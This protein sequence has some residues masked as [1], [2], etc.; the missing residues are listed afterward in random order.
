MSWPCVSTNTKIGMLP[1]LATMRSTSCASGSTPAVPSAIPFATPITAI[2]S[3]CL[4]FPVPIMMPAAFAFT[5]W[6]DGNRPLRTSSSVMVRLLDAARECGKVLAVHIPDSLG[7]FDT[8]NP[9]HRNGV[10]ACAEILLTLGKAL[11]LRL[12]CSEIEGRYMGEERFSRGAE[13]LHGILGKSIGSA[14]QP[15][16]LAAVGAPDQ[17]LVFGVEF[18]D[19]LVG[20]DHF[21]AGDSDPPLF[22]YSDPGAGCGRQSGTAEC[23]CLAADQCDDCHTCVA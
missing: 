4:R 13:S 11:M 17:R 23:A 20:L 19:T 1:P 22:G 5:S 14:D 8:K 15:A 18:F 21:R 10:I 7:I 6:P 16:I 12:H 2:A 9:P 3:P